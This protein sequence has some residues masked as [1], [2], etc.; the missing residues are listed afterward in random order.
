MIILFHMFILNF[1]NNLNSHKNIGIILTIP[2]L[3]FL[4]TLIFIFKFYLIYLILSTLF[5][6]HYARIKHYLYKYNIILY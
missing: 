4:G 1:L 5:P 2:L 6:E 3:Q